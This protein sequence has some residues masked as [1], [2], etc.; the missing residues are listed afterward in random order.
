MSNAAVDIKRI[1]IAKSA[2]GMDDD[3]YRLVIQRI[4]RGRTASSKDL[5]DAER[6]AVMKH[7]RASGFT[8]RVKAGGAG[9]SII[10]RP[11]MTKLR[12]MWWRLSEQ[13]A[14]TR[15]G[16]PAACDEAIA[17]WAERQLSTD[18]PPLQHIRFA[19]PEQWQRLVE[20][21]KKWVNRV[22]RQAKQVKQATP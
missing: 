11:E 7:M 14:V 8:P 12:A 20:S 5:T 1:H 21:M 18:S 9:A 17:A 16:G 10:T 13:A 3:T 19:T 2:L 6:A 22:A 4:S 15:P